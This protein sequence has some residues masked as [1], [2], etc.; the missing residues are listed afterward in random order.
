MPFSGSGTKEDPYQIWNVDDLELMADRNWDYDRWPNT[1]FILMEDIDMDVDPYN[2]GDGWEPITWFAGRVDG[3]HKTIKGLMINRPSSEVGLFASLSPQNWGWVGNIPDPVVENLIFENFDI[4]GQ[5]SGILCGRY[6][7]NTSLSSDDNFSDYHNIKNVHFK[8]GTIYGSSAIGPFGHRAI[9]YN[10]E[11]CSVG[12]DVEIYIPGG[13]FGGGFNGWVEY[14]GNHVLD[15]EIACNYK[16]CRTDATIFVGQGYPY[17]VGGFTGVNTTNGDRSQHGKFEQCSVRTSIISEEGT[18]ITQI[19]VGGLI[20]E[21]Q[22]EYEAEDCFFRISTNLDLQPAA[23]CYFGGI[24]GWGASHDAYIKNCYVTLIFPESS[25]N[26]HVGRFAGDY[27]SASATAEF[28]NVYNDYNLFD[29]DLHGNPTTLAT[30]I[31][32]IEN[33]TTAQMVYPYNAEHING[34]YVDWQFY[35][36]GGS[37]AVYGDFVDNPS[38]PWRHDVGHVYNDGYPFLFKPVVT[39][40]SKCIPFLFKV[41]YWE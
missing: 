41:P 8:S 35:P 2:T 38:G 4:I 39:L 5:S 25:T 6:N 20:A 34:I 24:V 36:E 27:S 14:D 23:G 16:Q 11:N 30:I 26:I 10:F 7:I 21:P 19:S 3:N 13:S 18:Y 15:G 9:N 17:Q 37:G 12:E 40:V 33:R 31:G 29:G 32:D 22:A 28:I 1:Y